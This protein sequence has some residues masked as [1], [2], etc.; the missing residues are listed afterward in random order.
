MM[1]GQW[2]DWIKSVFCDAG[3][4]F[5]SG[6]KARALQNLAEFRVCMGLISR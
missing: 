3:G 2:S 6:A 5:E 4:A 1:K